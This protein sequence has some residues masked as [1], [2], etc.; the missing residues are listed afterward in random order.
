MRPRG[1]AEVKRAQ[2]DGR[3][4][5][6]YTPASTAKAPEDLAEAL[7]QKPKAEAFFRANRPDRP[8][9]GLSVT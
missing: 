8:F 4:A 2:A 1:L 7:A 9:L 5:A 3:R 6:A